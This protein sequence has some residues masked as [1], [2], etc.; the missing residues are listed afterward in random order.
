MERQTCK[1]I[2]SHDISL[3]YHGTH[4]LSTVNSREWLDRDEAKWLL[5]QN[6]DRTYIEK[7]QVM[8]GEVRVDGKYPYTYCTLVSDYFSLFFIPLSVASSI[9]LLR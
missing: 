2:L 9:W 7:L 6:E 8:P 3:D 4:P 1:F 5:A